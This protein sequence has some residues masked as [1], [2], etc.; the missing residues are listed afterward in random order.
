MVLAL[1]FRFII[2]QTGFNGKDSSLCPY[3]YEIFK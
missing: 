3:S 2:S 1:G